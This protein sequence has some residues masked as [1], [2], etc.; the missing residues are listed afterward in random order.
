MGD[1]A[2][3]I[4]GLVRR[5]KQ[6]FDSG[7]DTSALA[8]DVFEGLQTLTKSFLTLYFRSE[9]PGSPGESSGIH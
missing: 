8:A 7:L 6:A 1:K 5:I 4:T 9:A 3:T 2:E